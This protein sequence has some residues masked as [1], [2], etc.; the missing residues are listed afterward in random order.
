MVA[1][2]AAAVAPQGHAGPVACGARKAETMGR[3][4]VTHPEVAGS[5]GEPEVAVSVQSTGRAATAAAAAAAT[6]AFVAAPSDA[7]A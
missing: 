6:A 1:G 4:Q 7:P 3:A 5:G 2:W